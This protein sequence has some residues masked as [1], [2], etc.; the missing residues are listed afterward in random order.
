MATKEMVL[1]KMADGRE[2]SFGKVQKVR[3]DT[4]TDAKGMPVG[5]RFDGNNGETVLCMFA[6]LPDMDWIYTADGNTVSVQALTHG[7]RQKLG[8]EYADTDKTADCLENVRL[9]WSRI[10]RNEW[11]SEVRGFGGSAILL[12]AVLL[13]FPHMPEADARKI[14]SE[15]KPAERTA[16]QTEEPVKSHYEALL[17]QSAKGADIAGLMAKFQPKA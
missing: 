7:Y 3:K 14:L 1:V 6:D 9:L 12:K 2:V 16:L 10:C 15:M 17:A 11:T 5:V 13:A 4:L 8:D